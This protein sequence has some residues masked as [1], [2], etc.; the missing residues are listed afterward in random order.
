[1]YHFTRQSHIEKARI[2]YL[3]RKYKK[4]CIP[5]DLQL[6]ITLMMPKH[7]SYALRLTFNSGE[8][9]EAEMTILE[10][11]RHEPTNIDI[12]MD[13]L[14]V[15]RE[16]LTRKAIWLNLKMLANSSQIQVIWFGNL[17]EDIT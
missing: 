14:R 2:A 4:L 16:T 13:Y 1:M 15:A 11:F 12:R 8:T 17:Q 6:K 5:L 10:A 7:G 9:Q 3:D